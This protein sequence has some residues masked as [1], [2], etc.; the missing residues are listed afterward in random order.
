M[1]KSAQLQ[2]RISELTQALNEFEA[3]DE[4][5]SDEVSQA[6]KR[7]AE[8][9]DTEKRFR[10]AL[11]SEDRAAQRQDKPSGPERRE[12]DK[13]V[14]QAKLGTYLESIVN[15]RMVQ[16]AEAEMRTELHLG[17]DQIPLDVL[18][19]QNGSLVEK[20]AD[21]VTPPPAEHQVNQQSIGQRV[22]ATTVASQMGIAMPTV[23][24]GESLYPILATGASPDFYADDAEA[25]SSAGSFT[26]ATVSPERVAGRITFQRQR[27]RDAPGAGTSSTNRPDCCPCQ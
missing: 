3:K 14:S 2:L 15:G 27:Q 17:G 1:T 18:L 8:L 25:D 21:A 5:T 20:R 7:Q 19:P 6:E 23:A 26:T 10:L 11:Q 22:F 16:G 4:P 9:I 24:S 13:L 12:W